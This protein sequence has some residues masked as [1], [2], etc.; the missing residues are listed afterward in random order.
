MKTGFVYFATPSNEIDPAATTLVSQ[1]VKI[2]WALHPRRRVEE[3]SCG[4]SYPLVVLAQLP[5][6]RKA[7]G[8]FHR[9]FDAE[10]THRE[11]YV[12]SQRL[13]RTIRAIQKRRRSDGS[14]GVCDMPEL[15][16]LTDLARENAPFI[17]MDELMNYAPYLSD[18][19]CNWCGRQFCPG[20]FEQEQCRYQTRVVHRG[21]QSYT[22]R[23]ARKRGPSKVPEN[24]DSIRYTSMTR[25]LDA[26]NS[27]NDGVRESADGKTARR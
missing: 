23:L 16:R 18:V 1:R 9:A 6:V 26:L 24:I 4:S 20:F 22:M 11:W 17:S 14:D 27:K 10:H 21:S 8:F 13:C 3:L 7:E 15:W 19:T 5:T 25:V 2:G 12:L